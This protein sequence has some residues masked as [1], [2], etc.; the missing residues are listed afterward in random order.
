MLIAMMLSFAVIRAARPA[1]LQCRFRG[2]V[3][4]V[5]L[6]CAL[7]LHAQSTYATVLG[8]V[9]DRT[10]SVLAGASITLRNADE[11]TV[12]STTTNA[13]GNYLFQF[14][15]PGH[16]IV[17]ADRNGFQHQ[18]IQKLTL[19]AR[20]ALRVDVTMRIGSVMQSVVVSESTGVLNTD[21]AQISTQ[22]DSASIQ[23]LPSN[24]RTDGS[25][26]PISLLQALPGVQPDTSTSS[27]GHPS[28]LSVEGG[29]PF[30]SVTTVD[31]ISTQNV[32][33]NSPLG[34]AFPSAEAIAEMRVDGVLNPASYDQPGEITTVTKAG[35]N[36]LHGSAFWYH[37][38]RVFDATPFGTQ[39]LPEI[40]GN[41]YGVS[42]GGPVILPHIYNGHDRTF[43]F[44]DF[45]GFQFPRGETLQEFVPTQLERSGDFSQE[46]VTIVDPS[47]G[48]PFPEDKIPTNRIS[49][50]SQKFLN[51]Y[52]LPNTGNLNVSHAANYIFNSNNNY[53]SNQFDVRIDQYIGQKQQMFGR[54]TFKNISENVPQG[55]LVPSSTDT[56]NYRMLVLSHNYS[57]TPNFINE[58][59]FG[60]TLNDR[61]TGNSTNGA[62][63]TAGL[64]LNGV[65]PSFPFD[66]LPELD[67][68]NISSLGVD[69][70][71]SIS[72]SR[73]FE[74]NDNISWNHGNH[75]VQ[76]GF[77]LQT[78]EA[79]T[80][81]SFFGADN[82]GTFYFNGAFSGKSFSDFLLGIPATTYID[83]VQFNN[84]GQAKYWAGYAED[85]YRVL[86][87][88][89]LT[90]GLRYEFHPGYTD[91]HGDI[92]NFDPNI[93]RTGAIV[94]PDGYRS[95]LSAGYLQTVNACPGPSAN[96]APCTPVLSN[97]QAHLP[98]YLRNAPQMV[99]PRFG[100]A[101]R[102]FHND[103]T[104]VRSGFGLYEITTLGSIYYSLTG[105]AQSN[106]L[107]FT[108]QQTPAGPAYRWPQIH[109]GGS[110]GLIV[111]PLGSGYFGT[112]NAVN[113][114]DPYSMQWVLAVDHNMGS[115]I[116]FDVSY[117]GMKTDNLVWAPND[118]DMSLST[119][120]AVD[121]PL[122][123]R[124]FPNWGTIQTRATGAQ[125]TYNTLQVEV[126]RRFSSGYSF[127][128]AYN[129]SKSLADN[130]GPVTGSFA[131]E[132]GGARSTWLY[133][134]HLDFGNVYGTRRNRWLTTV[135][136]DLPY[137]H[138]QRFGSSSSRIM[139]EVFGNWE[140]SNIFLWQ[141]GPFIT[142][143]FNGGDPSGTGS[144]SLFGRSQHPDRIGN[145]VPR[146][147]SA[148]NWISPGAFACPGTPNYAVG[149]PCVIGSNPGT[150]GAL[151]PIGRFGDA[152]VGS[153]VGPGTVNLSS[154][155]RKNFPITHEATFQLEGTFTN[156]LNHTNLADPITN[157][158]NPQFG[159]ITSAR[160]SDFGGARTGQV[161][162]RIQF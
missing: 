79:I 50:V 122:S 144:G 99:L 3:I 64:G 156:A 4:A 134:R 25:T 132:A 69:R 61:S 147:R 138:G 74:I 47:T 96:G 80:P 6:T 21:T 162:A 143:Y 118:N 97:S 27:N 93:P 12:R 72:Q 41:D 89:T 94:Y 31:G 20:Q 73:L 108:N 56:D 126:T 101:W 17:E 29:L 43:Y 60:F 67:F 71:N 115:N 111:G 37:Q 128:S 119:Q 136:Y 22:L 84:D 65:G 133:D 30:Q 160:T 90:Y 95:I 5:L 146:G 68:N 77:D 87:S 7:H 55:L 1:D 13:S 131:G 9:S 103:D 83:N 142:P 16:Y 46:G 139:N 19:T 145:P 137:G 92:A 149:S 54:F 161:S 123:D 125:S 117:I 154:G 116:A 112:A 140:L 40:I 62:Q 153:L 91:S 158:A 88:L 155:L 110:N 8:T 18:T 33:G 102:P 52:P 150:A 105:T 38:N 32:T 127:D 75:N 100:M 109:P 157:I 15:T 107:Q 124:P 44:A 45:E 63:F 14:V 48:L 81:L 36:Q 129:W 78:I 11:G 151:P 70:L 86:D 141:S 59:R 51:L 104:V 85:Q 121:R 66:G 106:T 57:F 24:F 2:V 135:V 39:V 114:K 76:A 130:Q 26:S 35:T 152:T 23:A 159:Q 98:N 49:P 42:S 113:W 58:F 82:Y 10:G 53:N 34:D 28:G 148:G 120:Y